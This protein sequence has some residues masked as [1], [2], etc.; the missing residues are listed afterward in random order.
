MS[1]FPGLEASQYS[2]LSKC[3]TVVAIQQQ[4]GHGQGLRHGG[5]VHD[6]VERNSYGCL[7][8]V[9][10]RSS[11]FGVLTGRGFNGNKILGANGGRGEMLVP[12]QGPS[13]QH[14][15]LDP[16][17]A[18]E[19]SHHQTFSAL[20]VHCQWSGLSFFPRGLSFISFPYEHV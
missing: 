7:A 8:R 16:P 12:F 1:A 20:N 18:G 5:N 15:P 2:A 9:G 4:E 13:Q 11:G 3:R 19:E 10:A 6:V 14:L 17:V